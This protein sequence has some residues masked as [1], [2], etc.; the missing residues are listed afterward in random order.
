MTSGGDA[1]GSDT[2]TPAQCCVSGAWPR[3][4]RHLEPKPHCAGEAQRHT[5][6]GCEQE[7][8]LTTGSRIII[9]ADGTKIPPVSACCSS[10]GSS[11][12]PH[13]QYSGGRLCSVP[14]W[15]FPFLPLRCWW[16]CQGSAVSG[17]VTRPC[18]TVCAVPL[19]QYISREVK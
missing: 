10:P 6:H 18:V 5:C 14:R 7:L 13:A 2:R 3:F 12:S 11:A 19:L 16:R 4:S 8:Y 9:R 15:V 1:V 17:C